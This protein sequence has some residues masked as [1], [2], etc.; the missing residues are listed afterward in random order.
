MVSHCPSLL[1]NRARSKARKSDQTSKLRA[2]SFTQCCTARRAQSFYHLSST[3]TTFYQTVPF[4]IFI[5]RVREDREVIA[6]AQTT[7]KRFRNRANCR[8]AKSK[9][10][11]ARFIVS[12]M[13]IWRKHGA[14]RHRVVNLLVLFQLLRYNVS[15]RMTTVWW[16]GSHPKVYVM[17]QYELTVEVK[18]TRE[19]RAVAST[20]FPPF[21]NAWC[22]RAKDFLLKSESSPLRYCTRHRAWSVYSW[23]TYASPRQRTRTSSFFSTPAFIE[24]RVPMQKTASDYRFFAINERKRRSIHIFRLWFVF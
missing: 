3:A 11:L 24:L 8:V 10:S 5:I 1:V 18:N 21:Q 6:C 20:P 4:Q 12:F 7:M 14:R 23:R 19:W 2:S 15:R 9:W 16:K 13:N 17:P 22:S